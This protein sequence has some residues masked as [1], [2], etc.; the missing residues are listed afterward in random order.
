MAGYEKGPIFVTLLRP[1]NQFRWIIRLY[2][3]SANFLMAVSEPGSIMVSLSV[4]V[5]VGDSEFVLRAGLGR[6]Y[7]G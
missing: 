3:E 2:E 6:D 4:S 1:Y 7:A 5:D